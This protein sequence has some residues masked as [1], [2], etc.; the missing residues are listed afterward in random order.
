MLDDEESITFVDLSDIKV[1]NENETISYLVKDEK[2]EI[3]WWFY[4][5]IA[6]FILLLMLNILGFRKIKKQFQ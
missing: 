2:F 6:L 1:L 3:V 4:L 5:M